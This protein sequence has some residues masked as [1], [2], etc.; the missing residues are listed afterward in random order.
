MGFRACD[1]GDTNSGD[2]YFRFYNKCRCSS[3]C[4]VE[5]NWEC[6][7]GSETTP[8]VCTETC[9]DGNQ[10]VASTTRCDDGNPRNGDG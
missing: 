7:G 3:T 10:I 2:G 6:S 5:T 9:G 8:D 4:T 1:D